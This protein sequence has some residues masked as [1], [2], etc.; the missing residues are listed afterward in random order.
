MFVM[1]VLTH[2]AGAYSPACCHPAAPL[3]NDA[4]NASPACSATLGSPASLH[5]SCMPRSL[6]CPHVQL[7]HGL[8]RTGVPPT[9]APVMPPRQCYPSLIL[10]NVLS[11]CMACEHHNSLART[12]ADVDHTRL[13][14]AVILQPLIHGLDSERLVLRDTDGGASKYARLKGRSR[15]I[16]PPN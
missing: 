8:L 15:S 14:R 5:Q 9:T 1:V 10:C 11:V 2:G 7:P 13:P 12:R 6:V 4:A 3:W 16:D